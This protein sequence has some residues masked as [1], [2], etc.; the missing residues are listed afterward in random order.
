MKI[1]DWYIIKKFLGTFFYSIALLILIVIVFDVSEKIDAFINN[2]APLHA[3][4]FQYYVNFIPYFINLFIYLFTFIS[5]VFFTSRLAGNSEIIAMLSNG[6]SFRR[7]MLPYLLSATLLAIMSFYMGNFLIPHTNIKMRKFMDKYVDHPPANTKRN[8]HVQISPGTFAYVQ[9][10]N[11]DRGTG[12]RFTLEK[13]DG[14]RL[15]YKLEANSIQRDTTDKKWVI[16]NYFIRTIDSTG[17]ENLSFGLVKD[18]TLNL[19]PTDLYKVKHRYGEMNLYE[20]NNFIRAEKEK[21]SLVYKRFE[22]E[23]YK[24]IAGPVAIIILTFMGMA[25][26]SRKLRGGMGLQLGIGI[27][28]AFTYILMMQVANVFSTQGNLSPQLGA[29]IPNMFFFAVA[30]YLVIKA[31]K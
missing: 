6:V 14:I 11:A 17:K 3:I 27:T 7:L 4:I 9:T 24:R 13:F 25:L 12:Y 20:L 29:W 22:I 10:F 26:S 8:V 2:H 18:T 31:P 28:M 19:K 23:K 1:L 30:V 16:T 5:V 21:G 15:V